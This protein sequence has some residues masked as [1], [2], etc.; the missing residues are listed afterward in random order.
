MVAA[1]G[2]GASSLPRSSPGKVFAGVLKGR[3]LFKLLDQMELLNGVV[4]VD[5]R[6]LGLPRI[7][8]VVCVG[9]PELVGQ[10]GIT[11]VAEESQIDEGTLVNSLQFR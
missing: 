8:E 5:H 2:G 9:D 3:E 6:P 11:S 7:D 1:G 4:V 10:G